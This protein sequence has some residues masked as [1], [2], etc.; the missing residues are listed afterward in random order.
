VPARDLFGM[1]SDPVE[2]GTRGQWVNPQLAQRQASSVSC[3]SDLVKMS[4]RDD[5]PTLA[6]VLVVTVYLETGDR[7]WTVSEL[8]AKCGPKDDRILADRIVDGEDLRATGHHDRQ[9][10]ELLT[11]QVLPTLFFA[12]REHRGRGRTGTGST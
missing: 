7:I 2:P 1:K 9:P 10:A 4:Y 8:G 11:A 6:S 3:V 12:E 5:A